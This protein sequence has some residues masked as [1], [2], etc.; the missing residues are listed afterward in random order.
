MLSDSSVVM[1]DGDDT[2][3]HGSNCLVYGVA[4][5]AGVQ[6]QLAVEEL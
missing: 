5:L 1:G 2:Q 4:A 3:D 6:E